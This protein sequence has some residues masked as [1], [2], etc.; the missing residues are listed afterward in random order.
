MVRPLPPYGRQFAGAR[1]RGLVP[2]RLG[3]GH[4]VVVLDWQEPSGAMPCIVIPPE[5]DPATY[6]LGF[7]AGLHVTINHRD[8][9]AGRVPS[10]VDA[11]LA[12]GAVVVDAVNREA[13]ARGDGLEAA[14]PRF[15]LEGLRHAA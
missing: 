7:V 12:A 6:D 3:L 5:S 13:L 8:E 2:R 9:H 4:L 10:V 11:L 15:E 14:W 1:A